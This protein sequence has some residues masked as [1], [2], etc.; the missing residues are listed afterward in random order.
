[1]K[2]E[3]HRLSGAFAVDAVTEEE[4]TGH[5]G[6]M[7]EDTEVAEETR[8]LMAAVAELSK[9]S[10]RTPP[11]TLREQVLRE[12]GTVRPL[13]PAA[14][15]EHALAA[16]ATQQRHTADAPVNLDRRRARRRLTWLSALAAAAAAIVAVVVITIGQRDT[17]PTNQAQAVISASDVSSQA[18]TVDDWSATLY[19]SQMEGKAVIVSDQMPDAPT[20][21]DFQVWLE[22]QD[23]SMTSAGVMPRTNG[24]GQEYVVNGVQGGV[25]AIAVSVE[26]A[27]GSVQPTAEPVLVV[28]VA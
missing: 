14:Q 15:Q 10:E 26:P 11:R 23:G 19:L 5:E 13:P 4:R 22:H 20:G 28:D 3:H 18:A 21:S 17:G 9:T 25:V 12:I 7:R 8:S 1:V 24:G 16:A 6:A 2:E 27:G